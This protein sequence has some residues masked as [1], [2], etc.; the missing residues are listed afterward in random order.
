MNHADLATIHV[1]ALYC[2]LILFAGICCSYTLKG[3]EIPGNFRYKLPHQ[4]PDTAVLHPL[5]HKARGLK[6][7]NLD[8][9]IM[10]YRYLIAQCRSSGYYRGEMNA[11]YEAVDYY[12]A[13]GMYDSSLAFC[14]EALALRD[15]VPED[16]NIYILLLNAATIPYFYTGKYDTAIAYSYKALEEMKKYPQPYHVQVMVYNTIGAMWLRM[17]DASKAFQYLKQG[18]ALAIKHADVSGLT[19]VRSNIGA[20]FILI[21]QYD[22]ARIYLEQTAAME[23][24]LNSQPTARQNLGAIYLQEDQPEK[25]ISHFRKALQYGK[26]NK[27]YFVTF[28]AYMGLGTAYY[29]LKDYKRAEQ[30]LLTAAE[31][32]GSG[33][34]ADTKESLYE[35]LAN[36]YG[37]TGR[38]QEAYHYQQ[39]SR[40]AF[41]ELFGKEKLQIAGQLEAKYRDRE[42]DRQLMAHELLI[43]QQENRIKDRNIWIGGTIG[44][45]F[46]LSTLLISFYRANR[47]RQ[48]IQAEKI[49][50]LEQGQEIGK[51]KALMDGEEQERS[52]IAHELH[53]GI[54]SQ[55]SAMML[56][57]HSIQDKYKELGKTEEMQQVIRLLKETADELRGTAHNLMPEFLEQQGL[58]VAVKTFCER[59]ARS[60]SLKLDYF[61]YGDLS[62]IEKSFALFLYRI[63]QELVQNIVKH[64]S[65]ERFA[66]MITLIHEQISITV[67]DDGSG[68]S[69]QP[70]DGMGLMS[71]KKRIEELKGEMIIETGQGTGTSISVTF[72]KAKLSD[73]DYG[74]ASH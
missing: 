26:E 48:K 24:L 9:A 33:M 15:K 31:M 72:A 10:L 60:K 4:I 56:Y 5:F 68:I 32:L 45:T 54:G 58:E 51:L 35:K 1:R 3:Q 13:R 61:T 57:L 63:I 19:H 20:A 8:S 73:T 6:K 49:R 25:A 14:L 11:L 59:I 71:M 66:V 16:H 40:E 46:L 29:K 41:S 53:D 21:K 36:V 34:I 67:E 70:S 18:E 30:I 39:L 37:A 65:A 7:N 27:D 44:I 2:F 50:N 22:T 47:N 69:G 42:K 17:E 28:T 62:R 64:A 74:A 12:N 43:A 23:E 55:H 52:R 38:Y